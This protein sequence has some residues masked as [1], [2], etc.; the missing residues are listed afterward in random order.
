MLPE[1]H[2]SPLSSTAAHIAAVA[3]GTGALVWFLSTLHFDNSAMD[4]APATASVARDV[5]VALAVLLWM[6]VLVVALVLG[7]AACFTIAGR[8]AL[9]RHAAPQHVRPAHVLARR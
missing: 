3:A 8:H 7:A 5:V 6:P 4:A 2:R 9:E 1:S